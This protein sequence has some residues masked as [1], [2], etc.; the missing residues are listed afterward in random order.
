MGSIAYELV[1]RATLGAGVVL[2]AV[3]VPGFAILFVVD[4]LFLTGSQ[5]AAVGC[6]VVAYLLVDSTFLVFNFGS[7]AG[8]QLAALHALRDAVLLVLLA[9][10]H[11]A[12][13]AAW[14]SAGVVFIVVY[15]VGEVI[16]LAIDL[17][18][19]SRSQFPPLAARSARVSPLIAASLFSRLAV[20]PGVS[21]PLFTP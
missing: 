18:F 4:L 21:W 2:F 6:T 3:N 13:A 11:F 8:S 15:L 20:S 5:L 19:F 1:R 16:L 9:L 7:L 17:G 10:A 12:F 14:G